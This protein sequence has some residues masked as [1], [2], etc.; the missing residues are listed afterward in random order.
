LEH[1]NDLVEHDI[2]FLE[3]D[4]DLEKHAIDLL[5]PVDLVEHG[6]ILWIIILILRA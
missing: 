5:E 2:D 3:H 1:E 6:M 4:A